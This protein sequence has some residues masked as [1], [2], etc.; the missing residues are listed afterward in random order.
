MVKHLARSERTKQF[1]QS[2]LARSTFSMILSGVQNSKLFMNRIHLQILMTEKSKPTIIYPFLR[3]S[4]YQYMQKI[5]FEAQHLSCCCQKVFK[6]GV[7]GLFFTKKAF[8]YIQN[9][10]NGPGQRPESVQ[11]NIWDKQKFFNMRFGSK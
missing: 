11:Q 8:I 1:V 5:C 2:S 3:S 9:L 4:K 10:Y 6:V 7:K